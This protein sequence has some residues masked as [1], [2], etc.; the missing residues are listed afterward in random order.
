MLLAAKRE[1]GV[2]RTAPRRVRGD[3]QRLWQSA[4]RAAGRRTVL[5]RVPDGSST[6]NTWPATRGSLASAGWPACRRPG[7][8]ATASSS[9]CPRRWRRSSGSNPDFV[10]ETLAACGLPR[11]TIDIDGT[12]I[13]MGS[14][15]SVGLPRAAACG[16]ARDKGQVLRGALV[17]QRHGGGTVDLG[18]L[19]KHQALGGEIEAEAAH[20]LGQ[21]RHEEVVLGQEV[22][23]CLGKRADLV[24]FPRPGAIRSRAR[25]PTIAWTASCSSVNSITRLPPSPACW[26]NVDIASKTGPGVEGYAIAPSGASVPAVGVV[27]DGPAGAGTGCYAI[28]DGEWPLPISFSAAVTACPGSRP[29]TGMITW[30]RVP[31]LL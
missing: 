24:P 2:V 8:S 28:R 1:P 14:Q 3:S 27:A 4:P 10:V 29:P 20:L 19:L 31:P 30:T 5:F 22:V 6:C 15:D 7:P 13:R 18:D 12:V 17:L 9:S 11:L 16:A 26:L 21:V 23:Q 25:S